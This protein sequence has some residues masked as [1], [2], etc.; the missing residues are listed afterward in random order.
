MSCLFWSG[1]DR[2]T[3]V[4][5]QVGTMAIHHLFDH[6]E[7]GLTRSRAHDS[8]T[9]TSARCINKWLSPS[10]HLT[11]TPL[12]QP[13]AIYE[14]S[15]WSVNSRKKC[16]RS[17]SMD[18]LNILSWAEKADNCHNKASFIV[19]KNSS[20]GK[21][22]QW[23]TSV[24]RDKLSD[25]K[26]YMWSWAEVKGLVAWLLVRAWEKQDWKQIMWT[27]AMWMH[28]YKLALCV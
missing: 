8:D 20:K 5:G 16:R 2:S 26:I 19:L 9:W 23:S 18:L 24:W 10:Y 27:K 6:L 11:V 4:I 21:S 1:S 7:L 15:L 25:V 3:T 22:S 14:H 28:L 12:F 13:T 17:P